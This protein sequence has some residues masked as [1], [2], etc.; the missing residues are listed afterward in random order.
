MNYPVRSILG[1]KGYDVFAIA[2]QASVYEAIEMMSE[3]HVGALP[4]ISDGELLGIISERD[5]ARNVVLKGRSS[6]ETVVSEIMSS[7]VTTVSPEHTVEDCM[8]MMTECRVRHLPV[9]EHGQMVGILSIGD[10]VKCIIE[11]QE[12]TIH[13]LENYITGKYPC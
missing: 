4:V 8:R 9:I 10:L 13:Q 7:P 1:Q 3:R 12:E 2:P 11:D 5:Y 6:K